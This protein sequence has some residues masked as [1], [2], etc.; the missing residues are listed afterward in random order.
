[1]AEALGTVRGTEED[2]PAG[3][4][5][6]V[7]VE[8]LERSD[9]GA[10]TKLDGVFQACLAHRTAKI[11]GDIVPQLGETVRGGPF[12]GMTYLLAQAEGC[13]IPKL[14]GCYEQELHPVLEAAQQG[15][16]QDILNIGCAEGYY[17]VGLARSMPGATI[18]AYDTNE[19]ARQR[20]QVLAERN[21]VAGRVRI[22]ET[23]GAADF[24]PFAGRTLVICD[25]E[26]GEFDLLDPARVPALAGMDLLVEI[27]PNGANTVEAF[28]ARFS[29]TH[30]VEVIPTAVRNPESFPEL[31]AMTPLDKS[32]ALIERLEATPWAYMTA[33][34]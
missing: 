16:F 20:C 25:I 9:L 31:A 3:F 10:E 17:A 34:R 26:G 32:L 24:A 1:M 4:I 2:G 8:T 6:K 33:K 11:A 18:H 19:T 13:I 23:M 27:H 14:L 28:T 5:L 7:V 30:D 29:D 21:G 15:G 22:G 12:A